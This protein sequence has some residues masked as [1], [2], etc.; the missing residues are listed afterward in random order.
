MGSRSMPSSPAPFWSHDI[1]TDPGWWGWSGPSWQRRASTSRPSSFLGSLRRARRRCSSGW[2]ILFR[3]AP[4]KASRRRTPSSRPAL[5]SYR[6]ND[7]L[8][9]AGGRSHTGMFASL[10]PLRWCLPGWTD[11]SSMTKVRDVSSVEQAELSSLVGVTAR[12][13]P[14]NPEP[15]ASSSVVVVMPAY[16][17]A[18]TLERTYDDIPH[19]LVDHILLVDDVSADATVQIAKHLGLDLT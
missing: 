8:S 18:E 3:A 6:L 14:G 15:K 12:L 17:A 16:N 2:T 5:S 11:R 13:Q 9:R 19:D 4:S 7:A 1:S 10:R